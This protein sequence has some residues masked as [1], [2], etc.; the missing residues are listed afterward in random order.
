[1]KGTI[2]IG[3]E[4]PGLRDSQ[5]NA[6]VAAATTATTT[7]QDATC[8]RSRL[9]HGNGHEFHGFLGI[10]SGHDLGR[11][12]ADLA[13]EPVASFGKRLDIPG[14]VRRIVQ[15]LADFVD[16]CAKVVVE[17]NESFCIPKRAADLFPSDDFAGVLQQE[18]Q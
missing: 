1:V 14:I 7:S 5:A 6:T 4:S 12:R 10:L 8:E 15:S 11:F 13:D 3:W 16:G 18:S 9:C 2:V 17:I